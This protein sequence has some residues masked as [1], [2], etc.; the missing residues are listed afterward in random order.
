MQPKEKYLIK[1]CPISLWSPR[2]AQV[3]HK[4]EHFKETKESMEPKQPKEPKE[5]MELNSPRSPR[6]PRKSTS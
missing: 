5:L 3:P 6:N 4:A 2:S 1:K